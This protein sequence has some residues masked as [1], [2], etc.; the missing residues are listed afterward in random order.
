MT[1]SARAILA[2]F[3]NVTEAV[4]YC[5][6]MARTYGHLTHEY[7]SYREEIINQCVSSC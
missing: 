6:T 3:R 4:D 7:R 2:R 1:P 5:E